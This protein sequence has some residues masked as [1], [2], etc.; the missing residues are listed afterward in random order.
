MKIFVLLLALL[1][2]LTA[3][4]TS[5]VPRQK[6]QLQGNVKSGTPKNLTISELEKIFPI[7]NIVI[8]DPYNNDLHTKFYGFSFIKL[9][10]K[11]AGPKAKTVTLK[12]IDGYQAIIAINLIAKENLFLTYRDQ[13]NYLSV[14]RMGPTR[15][16]APIKG[17]ISKDSLMK[18]GVNW[19]WQLNAIEFVE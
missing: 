3:E 2:G 16:I 11:Y 13:H 5:K 6:I 9:I 15:L 12:A 4:A 18:I 8:L 10:E 19:V 14:D 7:E 17:K 1:F